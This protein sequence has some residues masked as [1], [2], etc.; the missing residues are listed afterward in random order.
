[1]STTLE[2][3]KQVYNR[4]GEG[5][6]EGFLQ[7]CSE[8]IEWVINGPSTLEKC[9]AF[10]GIKGVYKFLEILK[11]SWEFNS[12]EPRKFFVDDITVIVLGEGTG[13]Y[14]GEQ[15]HERWTHVFEVQQK[16]IISFKGFLCHWTADRQPYAMRW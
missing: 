3:V 14:K 1:M 7:L 11:N 5:D 6:L 8:D 9:Q 13:V 4:F 12:F 10:H 2:V 16:R 15:F